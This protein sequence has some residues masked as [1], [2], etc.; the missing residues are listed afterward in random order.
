MNNIKNLQIISEFGDHIQLAYGAEFGYYASQ[1]DYDLILT[2]CENF[3]A[4]NL[5]NYKLS[6]V[7][8]EHPHTLNLR[9]EFTG[10]NVS[11]KL[12]DH[13]IFIQAKEDDW[14][15][16]D[17]HTFNLIQTSWRRFLANNI[18]GYREHFNNSCILTTEH[19]CYSL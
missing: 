10:L 8:Q 13:S 17:K 1:M 3:N 7:S 4:K 15:K 12:L 19:A 14:K 2:F 5:Q 9:N 6:L 16:I 18:V 11:I